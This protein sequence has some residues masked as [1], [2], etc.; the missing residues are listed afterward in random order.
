MPKRYPKEKQDG[1][2][3]LARQ[4]FPIWQIAYIAGVSESYVRYTLLGESL[5]R[6]SK[7]G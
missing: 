7:E 2:L 4:G 6:E 5:R 1:V 3:A